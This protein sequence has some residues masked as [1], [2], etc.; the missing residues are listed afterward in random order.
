MKSFLYKQ[1][2]RTAEMQ[3]SSHSFP[4]DLS[5]FNRKGVL[6]VTL[7][8]Q[9]QGCSCTCHELNPFCCDTGLSSNQ[10]TCWLYM[11]VDI[12]VRHWQGLHSGGRQ[13][14]TGTA[15]PL[16]A[17]ATAMVKLSSSKHKA[18]NRTNMLPTKYIHGS[19]NIKSIYVVVGVGIDGWHRAARFRRSAFFVPP[20]KYLDRKMIHAFF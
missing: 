12:S 2:Q 6:N 15:K 14:G 20:R 17:T 18:V 3:F 7:A 16:V 8:P 13:T 1:L 10:A 11:C 5:R 4:F 19:G 9:L